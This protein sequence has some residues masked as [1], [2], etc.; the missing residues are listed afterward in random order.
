MILKKTIN[1]LFHLFWLSF[2]TLVI[3]CSSH[4]QQQ[5]VEEGTA[6]RPNFLIIVADDLGFSDLGLMGSEI[7]TPALDQLASEGLTL[8]N[9]HVAP[10]CSPTRAMLLTGVDT[11]PAGLGT[12]SGEADELQEGQPGYEGKLSKRVV[13]IAT[14]LRDAGYHT[15]MVGKWH[16]GAGEGEGPTDRGFERSFGPA[17]GGASHFKDQLKM[18]FSSPEDE[19]ATYLEDGVTVDR[20]PDDFFSSNF[21]ADKLISQIRSGINDDRPFFAYAAFTAPHW[22]L[23]APEDYINRYAGVYDQ[24]YD[25]LRRARVAALKELGIIPTTT[26]PSQRVPWE[27]S[28]A[29]LGDEERAFSARRME[30]YAAMVENLD[31][32]IGRLLDYLKATNQYENTLIYFFSDNGAEGNLVN[33]IVE[34]YQWVEER[35][36]NSLENIG[37]EG[38]YVFTGPG[39]AQASTAPFRFYKGFPSEGGTRVPAIVASGGITTLGRSNTFVSVKDLAPTV[40]DY[41]GVARP[42]TSYRGRKTA[43]I[44]GESMAPLLRGAAQ[45]VHDENYTMGWELFGRRA[46]RRGNWKIVW[47]YAPYGDSR[48]WLFNLSSDPAETTDLGSQHPQKLAELLDAW[49]DYAAANGVVLPAADSGYGK[50]DPW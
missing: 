34:N 3:A 9:F 46:I 13:T 44:E 6:A 19:R 25:V 18:F 37:R 47:I 14:L 16:L 36:D 29:S 30:I 27:D 43:P 24:G 48:W 23:Q 39:W 5:R 31:F 4:P 17:R 20:L 38:S 1:S 8:T 7:R 12:M 28:W 32:N 2:L 33:R 10:T 50:E 45:Q 22:P 41:A 11:H 21:Y 15:Y 49:N 40:L 42:G 26:A 35:F